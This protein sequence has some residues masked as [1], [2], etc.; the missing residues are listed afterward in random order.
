MNLQQLEYII[1]VD[2]HRHFVKAAEACY[3]T[4]ATLS[5][6]VAAADLGIGSCH[7]SVADQDLARTILGHPEGH[8]CV[9]L[10]SFGYPAGRPLRPVARPD[11][12]PIDQVVHRG[13]W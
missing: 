5:M 13:R 9:F 4:Q 2:T 12:R 10:I 3:V 1:A 8:R 7:S 11:R 6:M